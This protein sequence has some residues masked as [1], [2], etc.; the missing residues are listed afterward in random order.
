MESEKA[1]Y[2]DMTYY[3]ITTVVGATQ[4]KIDWYMN[5]YATQPDKRF[6]DG[7]GKKKLMIYTLKCIKHEDRYFNQSPVL[8]ALEQQRWL[9]F[10]EDCIIFATLHSFFNKVPVPLSPEVEPEAAAV[11]AVE[12]YRAGPRSMMH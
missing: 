7:V 11:L 10:L 3:G 4:E 2:I 8:P 1:I 9:D 12:G 5:A 6:G